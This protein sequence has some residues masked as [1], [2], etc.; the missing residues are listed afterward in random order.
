MRPQENSSFI[1]CRRLS[2]SSYKIGEDTMF[3][4]KFPKSAQQLHTVVSNFDKGLWNEPKNLTIK[5]FPFFCH[6]ERYHHDTKW[7]NT[8]YNP[9]ITKKCTM[10]FLMKVTN[11]KIISYTIYRQKSN[12]FSFAYF[13]H[14][15]STM[16]RTTCWEGVW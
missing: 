10:L 3:S 13:S 9:K 11:H 14:F 8:F 12:K 5:I 4:K 7:E 6:W 16:N 1:S 15:K 2:S